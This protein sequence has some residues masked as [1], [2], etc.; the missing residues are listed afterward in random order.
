LTNQI[1]IRF[2]RMP[3][4]TRILVIAAMM[5][6]LFGMVIHLIEPNNFPTVFEGIW[7]AV[8]TA[9]TVGYGD[10]VPQTMAGRITGL[11]LLLVGTGFLSSYFIH[12]SAATVTKQNEYLEGKIG[13]KGNGHVIIIGWNERSRAIIRSLSET[14]QQIIL[15]D[16]SLGTNPI[17]DEN[18]HFIR[19]RAHRD[20]ILLK[21]RIQTAQKVII[22]SDQNLDELQADMNTVL[23]LLAIK[24]LNPSIYCIAEILTSEQANNARRAGAD[25]LIQTNT[26][27][28]AV[29]LN[30]LFTEGHVNSLLDFLGELNGKHLSYLS[31]WQDTLGKSF[32]EAS[33]LLLTNH[34]ILIGIKKRDDI[35][36]NP[37]NNIIIEQD[38]E[39]LAI[40]ND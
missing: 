17:R 26:L 23:T 3:I 24:G 8:I 35:F 29:I 39:L 19:G 37:Q 38:D 9:S 20:D 14:R 16:E 30:S 5:I 33:S 32:K 15:I 1:Y 36:V 2:I 10:Y 11:L 18:V 25:E 34:I 4:L 28:S 22:T 12:L 40:T 27:T 21:A 13:F 6:F 31:P 7:W